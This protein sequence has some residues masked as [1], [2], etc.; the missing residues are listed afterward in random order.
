MTESHEDG[1]WRQP[2]SRPRRSYVLK[3]PHTYTAP[4]PGRSQHHRASQASRAVAGLLP[5][6]ERAWSR[7][8]PVGDF[9]GSGSP[10]GPGRASG[11][12][13]TR[14]RQIRRDDHVRR[15]AAGRPV[16]GAAAGDQAQFGAARLASA[17]GLPGVEALAGEDPYVV[18]GELGDRAVVADH[19]DRLARLQGADPVEHRGP[20]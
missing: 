2:A 14:A 18:D 19:P 16:E 1:T 17:V 3:S 7:T 8:S 5:Q 11:A 13:Q 6:P 4:A 15:V 9:G 10:T 12:L 20:G